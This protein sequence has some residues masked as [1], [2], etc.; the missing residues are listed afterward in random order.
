M[1][2]N[3]MYIT[4]NPNLAYE[5]DLA[6]VDCLFLDL[7]SNGKQERQRGRNTWISNHTIEDISVIKQALNKA[8]LLVRVNPIGPLSKQE[9]NDVINHGADRIMLPMF[10]DVDE[11]GRF[12]DYVGGRARNCLLLETPQA[13]SR[14]DWI[15]DKYHQEIDC[16]HVGLNDLSIGL[17]LDFLFEVLSGDLLDFLASKIKKYEIPW[18][19][20]G[21]SRVGTGSLTAE[22]ILAEHRRLESSSVILSRAFFS[23]GEVDFSKEVNRVRACCDELSTWSPLQLEANRFEVK[24]IV[25]SIVCCIQQESRVTV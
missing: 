22:R 24:S 3:L 17:G 16:I 23:Q 9:I 4:N 20:G 5:A 18:G 11:V 7:E 25:R 2:L 14:I 15:L 19:F 12:L 13:L 6:G 10:C 1:D 8:E 21:V